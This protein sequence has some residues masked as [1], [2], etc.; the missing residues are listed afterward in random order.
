MA[1]DNLPQLSV[2]RAIFHDIPTKNRLAPNASPVLCDIETPLAPKQKSHLRSRL[3]R[4]LASR[5]AYPVVFSP[6]MASPVPRHVR[7]FTLTPNATAFVPLSR[8]IAGFLFEQQRGAV[9]PGLLCV[10]EV[11]VAAQPGIVLM[12]LEREEGAQLLLKGVP[13]QQTFDMSVLN[14]L[15]L[16]DGTRS[17]KTAA[18]IRTGADEDDFDAVACDEQLRPAASTDMA[19]FWLRFLGC[20][21]VLDPR[22]AT[23]RFYDA[24]LDFINDRITDPVAKNDL[25]EHLHSQLKSPGRQLAPRQFARD[26]IPTELRQQFEGHLTV[27]GVVLAAFAKD[28][29]DIERRLRRSHYTTSQG[30]VVSVPSD[31][32]D[33]VD[34]QRHKIVVSDTLQKVDHR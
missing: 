24:A 15:V 19:K 22:I 29:A 2:T 7:T 34:V 27:Q 16:T 23:Q 18:F 20:D 25:Y 17:F 1:I 3:I 14:N 6:V 33:L 30:A 8:D 10:L 21:F 26:F 28:L 9:S 11:A 12:K 31:K 5:L 4:V 13:G 32:A